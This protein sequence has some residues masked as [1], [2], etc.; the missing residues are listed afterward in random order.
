[1]DKLYFKDRKFKMWEDRAMCFS[2]RAT[3]GGYH[4][5]RM[6]IPQKFNYVKKN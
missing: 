5:F 4:A 2:Q 3:D 6:L 1:M